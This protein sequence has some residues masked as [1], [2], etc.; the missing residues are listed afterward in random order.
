LERG[1]DD[2]GGNT[3]LIDGHGRRGDAER[4]VGQRERDADKDDARQDHDRVGGRDIDAQQQRVGGGTGDQPDRRH[5]ECAES[6]DQRRGEA[7]R[8]HGDDDPG[9][10]DCEAGFKR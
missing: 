8:E 10:A 7:G 2:A 1:V 5:R 4:S 3:L 9:R 6:G